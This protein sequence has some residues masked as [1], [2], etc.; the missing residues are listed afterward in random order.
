MRYL[1]D[2][3]MYG[4]QIPKLDAAKLTEKL[5]LMLPEDRRIVIRI[6]EKHLM[7][8]AEHIGTDFEVLKDEDGVVD[9]SFITNEN[10]MFYVAFQYGELIEVLFPQSL[11]KKIGN[12][13]K[14]LS[15]R[16]GEVYI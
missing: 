3:A 4:K 2:A 16:H 7:Y 11:R 12:F 8:L 15:E 1:I 9:I 14:E 13:A 6:K 10:A 5:K